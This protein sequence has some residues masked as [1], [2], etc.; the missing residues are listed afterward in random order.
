MLL[1]FW[2]ARGSIPSPI[3]PTQ[4][5]QKLAEALLAAGQQQLDL[6]NLE[7]I[8]AFVKALALNGSTVGGNTTCI[9]VELNQKL[10]IFDAGSGIRELGEALMDRSSPFARQYGFFKGAGHAT[11]FFTHTH[12]DHIQG[13]PFF[14]P[15]LVTGNT[16]D[17]Y[18]VH[19]HVPATLD[20]QMAAETFPL[21]FDHLAA[22]LNFHQM[23]DTW[24]LELAGAQ[25]SIIELNHPGKAYAYRL[26]TDEASVVIATDS[27]YTNLDYADTKQYMDFYANADAMIFD[28]MFSVRES[29]I[30]EDWG[31]SSA[32]IG[33]DIAR[34]ANVKRLILFHHDPTSTDTEI[35]RVLQETRE[36]L[37]AD[38]P[39]PEVLVAQEGLEIN[40][41]R[42]AGKSEFQI[43]SYIRNGV[44]FIVLAGKLDPHATD[45][46]RKFLARTLHKHPSD[47]IVLKMEGLSEL[48]IAGIRA[49]VDVRKSVLTLALVGVPD[50]IRRVLELAGTI[51]FFAIYDDEKAALAVLKTNPK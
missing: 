37:G 11:I 18:H 20:R 29:F 50:R 19:P 23:A 2:G 6:T 44:L 16:F 40:L 25:I 17:I 8:K 3:T 39:Y 31:H 35:M 30:K 1:K 45:R 47:K 43:S 34:A 10:I 49:L 51:D 22:T 9:T 48:T 27:E 32:L 26:E 33:A 46:F 24:P 12:W 42:S 21:Q 28:A 14:R 13:L 15:M 36:Y 38:S 41:S 5:E 7:A 4:V